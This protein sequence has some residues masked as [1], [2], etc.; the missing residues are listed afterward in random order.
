MRVSDYTP[1]GQAQVHAPVAWNRL[2]RVFAVPGVAILPLRLFLGLTFVYASI[3][4]LTDPGFLR[5]GSG[6][7]IG[8]QLLAY[9]RGSPI[10]FF[11]LHL[12]EHAQFIGIMTILG[13]FG[14]GVLILAGLL[15]RL[16]ALGGLT[17]NFVFFL[18]ASWHAYPYFMGSDIVFVMAW[19]TLALTGPGGFALDAALRNQFASRLSEHMLDLLIGPVVV[20]D[21][22]PDVSETP[23]KVVITAPR[24]R[25]SALVSRREAVIG[26]LATG[27][28][29]LLGVWPRGGPGSLAS[30]HPSQRGASSPGSGG[31]GANKL[32]TTSQIPANSAMTFTDPTTG[33]PAAVIHTASA[34]FVAFDTVCTHAGCTVQYDPAYKL[35]VCPCHGGAF[36]PAHGASVVAGPPP[37][38]LTKI[39][40]K[41]DNNGNIFL[42]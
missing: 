20:E 25:N 34:G 6:T 41:I 18:S 23:D 15:T 10:R 13:E 22:H 24:V 19:L 21:D 11:L 12:M 29:F 16:A 37:A 42:A 14:I 8:A 4:K 36:D 3:Q 26:S 28:I 2:H 33:D 31:G 30:G 32:A 17:L 5:P 39:P 40:I 7:Y 35:L 9:S 1:E 38:P 27:A